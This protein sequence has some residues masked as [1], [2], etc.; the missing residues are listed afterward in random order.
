MP[1]TIAGSP[2]DTM[3]PEGAEY[4]KM[5]FLDK[6]KQLSIDGVAVKSNASFTQ[7]GWL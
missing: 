3:H 1:R 6:L 5:T 7:R 4:N 2:F